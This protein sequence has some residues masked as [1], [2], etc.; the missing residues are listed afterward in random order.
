MRTPGDQQPRCCRYTPL[1]RHRRMICGR[2]SL[3]TQKHNYKRPQDFRGGGGGLG[4]KDSCA[5][6][7]A[8]VHMDAHMCC[9]SVLLY[10]CTHAHSHM[11]TSTSH[12]VH[13][14][15]SIILDVCSSC[16][17]LR[18]HV[19]TSTR[20][21]VRSD[22]SMNTQSS[23]QSDLSAYKLCL[24]TRSLTSTIRVHLAHFIFLAM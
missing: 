6:L 14:H 22:Q 9:A 21:H 5:K 2:I 13:L 7:Y 17:R 19:H 24:T 15:R 23:R 18:P 10:I 3:N 4:A 16:P 20:K 1:C 8:C 11:A 12:T